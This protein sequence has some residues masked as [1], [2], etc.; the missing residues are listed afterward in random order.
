MKLQFDLEC[1]NCH[2]E[3]KQAV[4]E[5][6]PGTSR[7]CPYCDAEIRF[8]GDDGRQAQ[9]AVDNLTRTLKKLSGKIG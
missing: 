3:F 9:Q 2:R 7:H 5:V 6:R 4:A 8:T 1:P